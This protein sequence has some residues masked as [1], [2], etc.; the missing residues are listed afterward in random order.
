MHRLKLPVHNAIMSASENLQSDSSRRIYSPLEWGIKVKNLLLRH[1]DQWAIDVAQRKFQIRRG[2]RRGAKSCVVLFTF[3]VVF[4]A[5]F[6]L[7][8]TKSHR[9]GRTE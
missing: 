3:F 6:Y 2:A 9:N 7:F 1:D 4:P 8:S 5:K